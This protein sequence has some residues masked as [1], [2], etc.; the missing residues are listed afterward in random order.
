MKKLTLLF[1]AAL[2]ISAC[3]NKKEK[4]TAVAEESTKLEIRKARGFRTDIPLDPSER[5]LHHGRQSH[6]HVLYDRYGRTYVE[7]S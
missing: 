5:P 7:E 3:G 4:V 6:C 2:L 1:A